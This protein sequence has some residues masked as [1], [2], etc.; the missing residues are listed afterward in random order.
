MQAQVT[1]W[2]MGPPHALV[3]HLPRAALHAAVMLQRPCSRE[4]A[5]DIPVLGTAEAG[6]FPQPHRRYTCGYQTAAEPAS[7]P[8]SAVSAWCGHGNLV[9]GGTIKRRSERW[10]SFLT[11]LPL[12]GDPDLLSEIKHNII[13]NA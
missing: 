12:R 9:T 6:A 2:V 3:S 13:W 8:V 1:T 4:L 7:S 10:L 5:L 11:D